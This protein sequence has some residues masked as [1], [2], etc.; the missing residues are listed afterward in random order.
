MSPCASFHAFGGRKHADAAQQLRL[1][2]DERDQ[3]GII[4]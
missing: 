4:G 2:L 1:T 3:S